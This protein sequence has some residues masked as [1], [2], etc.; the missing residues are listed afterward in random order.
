MVSTSY[1]ITLSC[2]LIASSLSIVTTNMGCMNMNQY[3]IHVVLTFDF[4]TS[5]YY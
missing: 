5:V 1:F 3:V 4:L 2:T